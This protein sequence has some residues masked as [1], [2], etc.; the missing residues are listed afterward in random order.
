MDVFASVSKTQLECYSE[1]SLTVSSLVSKMLEDNEACVW[2]CVKASELTLF[3][4][5]FLFFSLVNR[6]FLPTFTGPNGEV[7]LAPIHG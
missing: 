6:C 5:S 3:V 2:L 1:E 7:S 4:Y